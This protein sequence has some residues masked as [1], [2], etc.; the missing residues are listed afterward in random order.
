MTDGAR[1]YIQGGA[2]TPTPLVQ[3]LA[4]RARALSGVTTVSLHLEGPAPH[5][6]PALE[7][8]LRSTGSA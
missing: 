8:H 5:V 1:V 7:G 4:D 6:D 3:A 2:A